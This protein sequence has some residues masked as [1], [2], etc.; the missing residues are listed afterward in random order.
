MVWGVFP[1]F[2]GWM[3]PEGDVLYAAD[4]NSGLWSFRLERGPTTAD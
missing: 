1:M 4:Y 3:Q 2:R